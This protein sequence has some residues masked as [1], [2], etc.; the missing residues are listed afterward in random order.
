MSQQAA[1]SPPANLAS[2]RPPPLSPPT[3][4]GQQALG[5]VYALLRGVAR[6]AAQEP[7]RAGSTADDAGP[8]RGGV[9]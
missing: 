3:D 6:R 5:S 2:S 1:A 9:R 4:A 7:A 8:V